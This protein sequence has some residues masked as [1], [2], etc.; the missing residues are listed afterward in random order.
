MTDASFYLHPQ[1]AGP[2]PT[3]AANAAGLRILGIEVTQ[4]IQDIRNTVS[5]VAGKT[6][7]VRVYVDHAS[8]SSAAKVT[9]ELEWRRTGGAS[10]LPAL[11]AVDIRPTA[12][13]NLDTQRGELAFSLNFRLP[14]AATSSGNLRL[15]VKRL[16]QPGSPDIPVAAQNGTVAVNFKEAPP[17]RIKVIG[18]RYRKSGKSVTP[19]AVDFS[20]LRSYLERAYPV[21][22]VEWSQIVVDANFAPPFKERKIARLANMQIAAIRSREV[23]DGVDPR[24]HYFGLVSDDRG[25]EFMRGEAFDIPDTASPDVVASSPCGTPKGYGGDQDASYADWYG[26][27]E[28]CHTMGR[29]HPGFPP[30]EHDD[31][32]DASDKAFP[33]EDGQ[34]TNTTGA[35]E[36]RYVGF[37]CGDPDLAFPMRAMHGARYHDIMTY[38]PNQWLSSYTYEAVLTRLIAENA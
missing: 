16:Y 22:S 18:L 8:L 29:Y 27:H 36:L 32:Q 19:S 26:T 25:T 10:Y 12:P 4:A 38:M 3:L 30:P 11:N 33:F 9:G 21:A 7:V 13:R 31:G 28:L 23:S 34:L 2:S 5:L 15:H 35:T 1:S 17:F 37:D 14:S 6:T 24:T 20:Y